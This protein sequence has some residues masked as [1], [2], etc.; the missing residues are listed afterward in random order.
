MFADDRS[1]DGTAALTTPFGSCSIP[2][3]TTSTQSQPS[4]YAMSMSP[5]CATAT[6]PLSLRVTLRNNLLISAT[7]R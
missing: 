4:E 5:H 7:R 2:V 3:E 1:R 6:K